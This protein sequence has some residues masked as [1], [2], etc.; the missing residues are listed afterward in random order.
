MAVPQQAVMPTEAA[1]PRPEASGLRSWHVRATGKLNPNARV[2][3]EE[4]PQYLFLI[5]RGVAYAEQ[6]EEPYDTETSNLCFFLGKNFLVTTHGGI[7][8]GVEDMA[9]GLQRSPDVLTNRPTGLITPETQLYFRDIYDHVLRINDA[10]D[11]YRELLSSTLDAYL[12]QVSIRLGRITTGL[13]IVATLSVPFVVIS[14]MW[15]MN[16][17]DLPLSRSANGF[18]ILVGAQLAIGLALVAVLRWRKWL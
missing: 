5:V 2:K 4:F 13:S 18:W 16:V 11:T 6:T 8:Q 10:L 12:S 17:A 3:I 15:G 14:G 1:G 9:S 7:A